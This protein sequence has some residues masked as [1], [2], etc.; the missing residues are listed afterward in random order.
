MIAPSFAA[1]Q[2]AACSFVHQRR[3]CH[4][5]D[6]G[7]VHPTGPARSLSGNPLSRPG[8]AILKLNQR[9]YN[10]GLSRHQ[11]PTLRENPAWVS[12]A[13]ITQSP[14]P[15][16]TPLQ[17]GIAIFLRPVRSD[18]IYCVTGERANALI[19][20]TTDRDSIAHDNAPP[21]GNGSSPSTASFDVTEKGHPTRRWPYQ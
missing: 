3:V 6:R 10:E 18:S 17:E 16:H 19:H 4:E 1:H 15:T 21:L 20:R 14:Y 8:P 13:G 9:L 7:V 11:R 2:P 12:P 5:P